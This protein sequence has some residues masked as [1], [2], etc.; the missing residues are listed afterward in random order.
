MQTSKANKKCQWKRKGWTE[1]LISIYRLQLATYAGVSGLHTSVASILSHASSLS[2]GRFMTLVQ[3]EIPQ[4]LLDGLPCKSVQR[5]MVPRGWILITWW[6]SSD[7]SSSTTTRLPCDFEW[8]IST[9]IGGIPMTTKLL[10]MVRPLWHSSFDSSLFSHRWSVLRWRESYN[11]LQSNWLRSHRKWMGCLD[12]RS[13]HHVI[14][15]NY[16]IYLQIMV[17]YVIIYKTENIWARCL[18]GVGLKWGLWFSWSDSSLDSDQISL[19]LLH[20][21]ESSSKFCC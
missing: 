4:P 7:H 8:N 21:N 15:N 13:N 2:V 20:K 12:T 14:R 6:W 5:F 18:V 11:D 19:S 16:C 17:N 10:L 9:T 1:S 3:T